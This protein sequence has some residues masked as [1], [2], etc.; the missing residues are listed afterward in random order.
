MPADENLQAIT[1]ALKAG[2]NKHFAV[3]KLS[4]LNHLFQT[5]D[6]GAPSEYGKIEETM[7]PKA[8]E[9]I[10]DWILQQTKS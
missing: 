10:A 1:A 7:S 9:V 3:K 2:G 4:G 5:A 6:T 8:M